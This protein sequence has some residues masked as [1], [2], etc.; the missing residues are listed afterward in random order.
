LLISP[1]QA[2]VALPKTNI[3]LFFSL[4]LIATRTAVGKLF[5]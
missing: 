1:V 3:L 4:F 2:I 5:L